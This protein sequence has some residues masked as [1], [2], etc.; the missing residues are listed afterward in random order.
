MIPPGLAVRTRRC[1]LGQ[2]GRV[3]GVGND[4]A[5]GLMHGGSTYHDREAV[6]ARMMAV[7]KRPNNWVTH[8]RFHAR[9][10]H[11]PVELD[12]R[13]STVDGCNGIWQSET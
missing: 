1:G 11:V 9:R 7:L 2:D 3:R 10:L 8:L 6:V 12:V 4:D 13:Q 5:Q